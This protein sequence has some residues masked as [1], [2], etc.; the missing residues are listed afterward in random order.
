VTKIDGNKPGG[1]RPVS[2]GEAPTEKP[3]A[4]AATDPVTRS[5]RELGALLERGAGPALARLDRVPAEDRPALLA[6]LAEQGH[7][8]AE[9]YRLLGANLLRRLAGSAMKSKVATQ[10]AAEWLAEA[11]RGDAAAARDLL[12]SLSPALRGPTLAALERRGLSFVDLV[13]ATPADEQGPLQSRLW[14]AAPP[15]S[16][17]QQLEG[18]ADLAERAPEIMAPLSKTIGE[19]LDGSLHDLDA[20][21]AGAA[22][23]RLRAAGLARQV[24]AALEQLPPT[25]PQRIAM[26]DRS[27][28]DRALLERLDHLPTM[29]VSDKRT[30]LLDLAAAPASEPI[31]EELLATLDAVEQPG[32]RY[33][34]A[35]SL[36]LRGADHTSDEI[37]DDGEPSP[38]FA[39][40]YQRLTEGMTRSQSARLAD[41]MGTTPASETRLAALGLS[42][43]DHR[44]ANGLLDRPA[45]AATRAT[46]DLRD[47]LEHSTQRIGSAVGAAREHILEVDEAG[48]ERRE[49]AIENIHAVREINGNRLTAGIA[50]AGSTYDYYNE[51]GRDG[52]PRID[53][54]RALEE[55]ANASVAELEAEIAHATGPE[56]R[57]SLELAR[58]RAENVGRTA[59]DHV[60]AFT[61]LD[62]VRTRARAARDANRDTE[63]TRPV[64]MALDLLER[65]SELL[66][67]AASGDDGRARLLDL[68]TPIGDDEAAELH[69]NVDLGASAE[70]AGN[71]SHYAT[72]L[73]E[74]IVAIEAMDGGE[75]AEVLE[76]LRT[77]QKLIDRQLAD[78]FAGL[79]RDGKTGAALRLRNPA[80]ATRTAVGL[81]SYVSQ[82]LADGGR[83][84]AEQT[85]SLREL[86]AGL[87]NHHRTL[88]QDLAAASRRNR[89]RAR[90]RCS[91]RPKRPRSSRRRPHCSRISQK[92]APP[93]TRPSTI[94]TCAWSHTRPST[95]DSPPWTCHRSATHRTPPS[96]PRSENSSTGTDSTPPGGHCR[97]APRCRM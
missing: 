59:A 60:R 8:P 88:E 56:K 39:R 95:L 22:L 41:I 11:A 6:A 83:F 57:A 29:N 16:R 19:L 75:S 67:S 71:L 63:P 79:I 69:R 43:V 44:E 93:S 14:K 31:N 55:R 84:T 12:G 91:E 72:R 13:R 62:D 23:C 35:I 89:Q 9:V 32:D 1:V 61:E 58:R 86:E 87:A 94:A 78:A 33:E 76:T 7:T 18:W 25:S 50:R 77:E 21:R 4:R 97:R 3:R 54:Y 92:R 64:A 37:G 34:L 74:S 20:E 15:A 42:A 28:A 40:G 48:M 38:A 26:L 82:T 51:P 2:E 5:A 46:R 47:A 10:R 65:G 90:S 45:F 73:I 24:D 68:S 80:L 36:G 81:E 66:T 17:L 70:R 52:R 30:L 27:A 53:G 49:A 96:P 85:A